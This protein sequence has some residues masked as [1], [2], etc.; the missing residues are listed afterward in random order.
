MT[1][2]DPRFNFRGRGPEGKEGGRERKGEGE[3]GEGEWRES[4]LPR[5]MRFAAGIPLVYELTNELKPVKHYYTA[6]DAEVQAAIDKV[7]NQGKSK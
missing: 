5:S 3:V 6:S 4:E 2:P 7:A 1:P